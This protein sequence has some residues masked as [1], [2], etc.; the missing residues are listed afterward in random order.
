MRTIVLNALHFNAVQYVFAAILTLAIL[1]LFVVLLWLWYRK[2]FK[3]YAKAEIAAAERDF[4]EERARLLHEK[5]KTEGELAQS[6]KEMDKRSLQAKQAQE[7]AEQLRRDLVEL[8]LQENDAKRYASMTLAELLDLKG[9]EKKDLS[10]DFII[11]AITRN[12]LMESKLSERADVE[13]KVPE[14]ITMRYTVE[15]VRRIVANMPDAEHITN[16]RNESCKIEGKAFVM[17]YDLHDGQFKLTLKCGAY[18]ANRLKGLYPQCFQKAAFPGGLLWH[19]V[20]N[21]NGTQC[22][23]ELV[24]LLTEISYNISKAGY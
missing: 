18:Y 17:L 23:L 24:Q 13:F 6:E 10:S 11:N 21:T 2:R 8:G 16:P 22:S 9:K 4:R 20:T 5:K 14:N 3:S 7:E 12:V 19:T 1:V 15:A